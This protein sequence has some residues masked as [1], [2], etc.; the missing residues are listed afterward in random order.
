MRVPVINVSVV[1]L[2]VSNMVGSVVIITVLEHY[3]SR[4]CHGSIHSL[5]LIYSKVIAVV[6]IAFGYSYFA[7]FY[8]ASAREL[9]RIGRILSH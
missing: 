3:F 8:R 9:K 4:C 1:I 2:T 7:A 6:G 5:C